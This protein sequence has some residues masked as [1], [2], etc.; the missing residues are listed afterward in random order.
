MNY[1]QI[2]ERA[3]YLAKQAGYQSVE[4]APDFPMEVNVAL[5]DFSWDVEWR[6]DQGTVATVSGTKEYLLSAAGTP[7]YKSVA[8]M[9]RDSNSEMILTDEEQMSRRDILWYIRPIGV[10][11]YFWMSQPNTIILHPTPDDVYTM[12]FRGVRA[13]AALSA[14][15]DIPPIAETYHEGI[16]L[17]AAIRI[18]E[19]WLPSIED[20]AMAERAWRL[21]LLYEEQYKGHVKNF[22]G[23]I[24]S[25]NTP[26]Q[27]WSAP[28]LPERVGGTYGFIR[29]GRL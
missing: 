10:P 1:Q 20:Q 5:G 15:T 3:A 8:F 18:L 7:M 14:A 17:R 23:L 29:R 6:K 9:A 2:I 4:P 21:F 26:K 19:P 12:A 22:R 13:A 25:S 24:T 27:R 11:V 16:A 28:R